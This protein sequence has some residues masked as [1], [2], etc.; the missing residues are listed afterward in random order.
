M[1]LC[2]FQK[3]N[4]WKSFCIIQS[5]PARILLMKNFILFFNFSLIKKKKINTNINSLKQQQWQQL[6]M[7][8]RVLLSALSIFMLRKLFYAVMKRE[9]EERNF[10]L[11]WINWGCWAIKFFF[12]SLWDRKRK[13]LVFFLKN[14]KLGAEDRIY[15]LKRAWRSLLSRTVFIYLIKLSLETA[16]IQTKL[17]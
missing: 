14:D 4:Y 2:E 5:I 17:N 9:R 10:I 7:S 13:F 12:S 16:W 3:K 6:Q 8:S 1:M 15:G 11:T